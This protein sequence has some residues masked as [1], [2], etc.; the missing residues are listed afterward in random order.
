MNQE[1]T[2]DSCWCEVADDPV[3]VLN[4]QPVKASNGWGIKLSGSS[5]LSS[6][7]WVVAKSA[8][9]CEGEKYSLKV[10]SRVS[11]GFRVYKHLDGDGR[12][13]NGNTVWWLNVIV[14]FG[15]TPPIDKRGHFS[16]G[17]RGHYCFGLTIKLKLLVLRRLIV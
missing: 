6:M 2:Q 4:T 16:F 15:I 13:A 14:S 10:M 9:Y 5:A 1:A 12:R 7:K 8:M 11:A 17:Q 3:V